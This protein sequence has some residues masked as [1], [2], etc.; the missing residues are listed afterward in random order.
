ML[1]RLCSWAIDGLGTLMHF[2][3]SVCCSTLSVRAG[4]KLSQNLLPLQA[5]ETL[6]KKTPRHQGCRV[7][8]PI[9]K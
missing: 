3:L 7:H 4:A 1:A 5:K 8:E 9:R 6:V 2:H